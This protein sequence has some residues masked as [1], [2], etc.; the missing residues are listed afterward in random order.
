[1]DRPLLAASAVSRL[2]PWM[3]LCLLTLLSLSDSAQAAKP[4]FLLQ[5]A[6]GRVEM[7]AGGEGSWRSVSRSRQDAS[8]GDHV[9]TGRDGSVQ[10]ITGDG[11]RIA[12]GADTEIVLREPNK[13]SGW[14]VIIG[15]VW[16]SVVGS[17]RVEVRTPSAV[18]AAEGT[19]F[20][21]DVAEDGTTVLTVVEG[22]VRFFNDLGAV[23]VL[24]SQQSTARIGEAPTRPI[25][26]D[27]SSL[28]AW[29]ASLQTLTISLEYPL[30]STDP[31]LLESELQQRERAARERP[32]DSATHISLAEVL[33]DLGRTEEAL[34]Y[35]QRVVELAPE[36]A[37]G[38][39]ILGYCLLQ[40]GRPA[41]AQEQFTIASAAE[42]NDGRWQTGLGL[43]ALG[44]R[45]PK[46]AVA[47]F[48]QATTM[49]LD[50]N[51]PWAYLSVAYL[52]V[53]DL[54]SA[55]SSASTAVSLGPDSAIANTYL[56]YVR[57]AQGK[58]DEAVASAR[59]AVIEAPQSALAHEALGTSLT[60]A[61]QFAEA[62]QNLDRAIELDPLSAGARLARAKLLAGQ[63]EI[64]AALQDAQIAVSLDPQSAPA[65]S[66]LGL[67]FLLVNDPHRA[68]R[69][70]QRALTAEPSLSEA[71]TGW[72]LVLSKRGR[73]RE[74]V[75]QQEIAVSL[76]T[77]SASAQN[78]LGALY[79]SEGRMQQAHESLTHAIQ[80]QPG[81][82]MPYANLALLYLEQ[83][84]FRDALEAGE[85]AVA[86]GERS[87]FAHTVL[88][89]VYI[90]QGRIDRAL[91][92]LRQAVALDDQY[93]Q[94]HFQ[95]A[96]L[97][98]DQDRS[99]DAVREIVTA[100]TLD[101]SAMLEARRYART[102][103]AAAVGSFD[104]RQ[105]EVRHSNQ[106]IDGDLSYF[107]SGL[108]DQD[109]GFRAVNQDE[110]EQF[111]EAI[112]GYQSHP[113]QQFAL[114]GT[115]FDNDTGMPGP[116]TAGSLGDPDDRQNFAGHDVVFAFRQRLSTH[117]TSTFKYTSRESRFRFQND[118]S[119]RGDNNPFIAL[120]NESL[121]RSPEIRLD[122]DIGP[123]TAL[124]LGYAH[125]QDD[126]DGN[127]LAM[128]FDPVTGE[129]VPGPFG[130]SDVGVIQT[131]W[132]EAES[133]LQD[134]FS[135]ALGEYWGRERGFAHVQ[136]PKVVA[137]YRPDKSKWWAFVV[138]PLFRSD[139]SELAPV[140]AL[141]DPEGLRPL[142]FAESGLG[143]SYEL[144]F[145]RQHGRS[146]TV[147]TSLSYQQVKNLLVDVEDPALTGLPGR[148]LLTK[149]HR[150][151]ADAA[152]EQWLADTLTGRTWVRWQ[153]SRG[154]FPDVQVADTEWPYSPTWQA[155]ARLDY[156][157]AHGWLV[158]LEA[159]AVGRRFHNPGNSQSV[160]GYAQVNMRIRFQS[161]LHRSYFLTLTNLTED[162]SDTFARFPQPGRAIRAGIEYR[163]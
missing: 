41:E 142:N 69:E 32:D 9:R 124:R 156:I 31:R 155:G 162:T 25:V 115:H 90:R 102:E 159:V 74:A 94:A 150:W 134:R 125:L 126:R 84:R 110:S 34:T 128:L 101:P 161:D 57:L 37:A 160:G 139:I 163:F 8:V 56:A 103:T 21:L 67:L 43:V 5:S 143:R 92:E 122:A 27:P 146:A 42:P 48:R 154:D 51:R 16:A 99:R 131:G 106:A 121:Q 20:V 18:A 7:Q 66:T 95:L 132:I 158:G 129:F 151:V 68:G 79:A 140:E 89:R 118:D 85:R 117:I 87:A 45:D 82:G 40:A 14:R 73:F 55:A 47:M 44:Q 38:H 54:E 60:F 77:D 149:G 2:L 10:I 30:E 33:L 83:N 153:S 72:G 91:D 114:F 127:G 29:E 107:V 116:V 1:M 26:V 93:P 147:A 113:S 111:L 97:Y 22:Q 78:N 23:T 133:R 141:A 50:D 58:L 61:G 17:S 46:P 39:G 75:E 62:K 28:T 130:T 112:A 144:R 4:S 152:Y 36:T 81:W 145:Q 76:D 63:G 35:A 19:V 3:A 49:A 136:S 71:R 137:L 11:T 98:L 59:K 86:L 88:A 12:M 135:L 65:H 109:D 52:R 148:V 138:N 64:E 96:R 100:V 120:V 108:F 53:G 157:N 15:R 80:L 70:F 24:G 123:R 6:R 119:L 105:L 104:R 13:P